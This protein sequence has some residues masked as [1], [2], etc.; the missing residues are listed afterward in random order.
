MIVVCALVW[1]AFGILTF[2]IWDARQKGLL[3]RLDIFM[4]ILLGAVYGPLS[5]ICVAVESKSWQKPV[6]QRQRS[7][8]SAGE[9]HGE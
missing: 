8:D 2:L 4:S 1:W 6:W 9:K 7:P 5:L 3:S